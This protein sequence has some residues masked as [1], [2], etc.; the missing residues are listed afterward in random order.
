MKKSMLASCFLC[1]ATLPAWTQEAGPSTLN[2]AGGSKTIAGN[3]HEFS[4]G[5]MAL[6]S[7][8]SGAG[9]IV[10]QGV[11]QPGNT[12]TG[13]DDRAFFEGNLSLFPNPAEDQVFLQPS[14]GAG[15]RLS[16]ELYDALGR[17]LRQATA[18]LTTGKEK[19][20]LVLKNLA[21]S[22]YTLRISFQQKGKTYT[23]AYKI[24]KLQ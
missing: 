8:F 9:I 23:T 14:F 16:Y 11:L 1:M 24:Q 10:T 21:A 4:I 18:T 2:A 19:Q 15:G 13:I 22:T 5:E 17:V 20:T 7:T 6:V 3:T 12:I